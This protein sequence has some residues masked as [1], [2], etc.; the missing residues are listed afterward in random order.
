MQ[1]SQNKSMIISIYKRCKL[2]VLTSRQNVH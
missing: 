2:A 1:C